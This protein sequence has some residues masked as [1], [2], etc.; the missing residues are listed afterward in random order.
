MTEK[1]K[2]TGKIL[3]NRQSKKIVNVT[4]PKK[5]E[6]IQ[7]NNNLSSEINMVVRNINMRLGDDKTNLT[8]KTLQNLEEVSLKMCFNFLLYILVFFKTKRYIRQR[9][10]I[11]IKNNRWRVLQSWD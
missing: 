11:N 6:I 5:D 4:K 7:K 8:K 1:Q 10:T 2:T 9:S 3:N